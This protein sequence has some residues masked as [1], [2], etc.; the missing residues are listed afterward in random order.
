[1]K[2]FLSISITIFYLMFVG[3]TKSDKNAKLLSDKQIASINKF[4]SILLENSVAVGKFMREKGLKHSDNFFLKSNALSSENSSN[5]VLLSNE[6][7]PN[8]VVNS[9]LELYNTLTEAEAE[10]L[11]QP[12]YVASV[13][14]LTDFEIYQGLVDEFQDPTIPEI[15]MSA[16][17]VT[18]EISQQAI[19]G[20]TEHEF[21]HCL[22]DSLGIAGPSLG[23]VIWGSSATTVKSIVLTVSK[24]AARYLGVIGLSYSIWIFTD[25][26]FEA[27]AN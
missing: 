12:L 3:C 21:R 18:N 24:F 4:N 25:C 22:M 27:S 1:M 9:K 19:Y 23:G 10:A 2:K 11:L 17:V 20:I 14:L 26:M 8:S 5:G 7:S 16:L 6:L 15:I 13:D